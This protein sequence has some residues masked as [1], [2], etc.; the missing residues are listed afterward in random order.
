VD[1][2]LVVLN[3]CFTAA[4]GGTVD[5]H[6]DGDD[7]VGLTRAFIYAGAPSVV[8]T[9]WPVNDRS[10]SRFMDRFYELLRAKGK[11]E[12]LAQTQRD[13]ISGLIPGA[14]ECADPYH[15]APFVLIGSSD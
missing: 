7:W 5:R 11:G 4:G 13:M 2:D 9:L 10:A 6:P 3:G 8:A 15:W 14:A 12:A 1:A